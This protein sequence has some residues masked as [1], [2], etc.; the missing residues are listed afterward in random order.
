[1]PHRVLSGARSAVPALAK[2]AKL[3]LLPLDGAPTPLTGGLGH[4]RAE[5][6]RPEPKLWPEPKLLLTSLLAFLLTGQ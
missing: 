5:K 2:P 6:L 4:S 3:Q 1:M